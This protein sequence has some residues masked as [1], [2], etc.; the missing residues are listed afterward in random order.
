M[1]KY[2]AIHFDMDG[3]IVDS[4]RYHA[5]SWQTVF[6]EYGISISEKDIFRREGM[7]GIDSIKDIFNQYGLTPPKNNELIN[8]LEEKLRIFEGFEI[9][10]FPFVREI[11]DYLTCKK[12]LLSLVT[13]SLR[14]S[15]AHV[16]P[17]GMEKYFDVIVTVDDIKNGKPNPEP[18]IKAMGKLR[19][20]PDDSLAIENAPLGILSAKRADLCC[21]A[22][23][24]SLSASFLSEADRVFE[25]HETLFEYL[26]QCL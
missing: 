8:L 2:K 21:Y 9:D 12:I 25:D 10:V 20:S 23:A 5:R 13:G 16:I 14:R 19:V 15:V 6:A 18:Y 1:K 7:P 11:L 26:K 22:I 24:T 4:M 3:V 17:E